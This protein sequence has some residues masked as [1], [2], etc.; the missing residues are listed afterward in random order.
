MGGNA[1]LAGSLALGVNSDDDALAAKSRRTFINQL[2]PI[3]GR[4][5]QGNLVRT[6]QKHFAHVLYGTDAAAY[7]Q[8]HEAACRR[9]AHHVRHGGTA[10]GR[11]GNIQKNKFIRLLGIIRPGTFYRIPGISQINEIGPLDDPAVRYVQ[12]R[13]DSFSQHGPIKP[14]PP[15]KEKPKIRLAAGCL[16][17]NMFPF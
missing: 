9:A 10:I 2:R 1:P 7:R 4:R 3:D 6:R 14:S 12:T 13:N 5:I 16:L 17:I 8:R 11:S 15:P